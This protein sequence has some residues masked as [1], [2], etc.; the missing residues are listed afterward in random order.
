MPD[1]G[2]FGVSATSGWKAW[3][4]R[5]VTRSA[6]NHAFVYV[7]NGQIVEANPSGAAVGN[8]DEYPH[9]IWSHMTLTTQQRHAIANAA[10]TLVG[11]PYSWVDDACIGLADLFGWHVPEPVRARLSRRSR[12][13]CSQLVDVA[14][15]KAG[16]HLFPDGRIP[17]DVSPGDLLHLIEGQPAETTSSTTDAHVQA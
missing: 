9:A 14:Y 5:A 2:A 16:V 4:I 13:M 11:T 6:V 7:G 12:L 1:L 10:D 15:S 3:V 8:V 17:G